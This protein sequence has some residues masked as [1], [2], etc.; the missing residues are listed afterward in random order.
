MA[1]RPGSAAVM[2][3]FSLCSRSSTLKPQTFTT[4]RTC[5]AASTAYML[6]GLCLSLCVYLAARPCSGSSEVLLDTVGP[7]LQRS[8]CW[9]N[10]LNGTWRS[11]ERRG[12]RV[13]VYGISWGFHLWVW[14]AVFSLF[15]FSPCGPLTFLVWACF[16]EMRWTVLF[17]NRK[18][19][20]GSRCWTAFILF[21]FI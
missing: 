13:F 12:F 19:F 3:S 6:S 5:R 16:S 10:K 15:F 18:A 7:L 21:Y 17:F 8:S 20:R 11:A 4:E 9:F 1:R 2:S 14:K